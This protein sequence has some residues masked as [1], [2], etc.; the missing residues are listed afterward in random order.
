[1]RIAQ[2]RAKNDDIKVLYR[3][4]HRMRMHGSTVLRIIS[5]SKEEKVKG[6]WRKLHNEEHNN[7]YSWPMRLEVINK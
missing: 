4:Q 5:D 6:G 1:M 3:E 7:L 2:L